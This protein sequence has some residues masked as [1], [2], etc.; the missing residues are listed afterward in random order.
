[1]CP[2]C[3]QG[4]AARLARAGHA[5]CPRRV[6]GLTV[7]VLALFAARSLLAV[8]GVGWHD[9]GRLLPLALHGRVVG[10]GLLLPLPLRCSPWCGSASSSY[11]S[12]SLALARLRL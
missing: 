1:M 9:A 4:S 5:F 11:L 6:R 12:A 10:A 3:P 7:A 8:P 2:P